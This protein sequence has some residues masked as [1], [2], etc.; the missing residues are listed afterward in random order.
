MK[1]FSHIYSTDFDGFVAEVA[2]DIWNKIIDMPTF[3]HL[4]PK[5]YASLFEA[6]AGSLA[7][8]HHEKALRAGRYRR[9]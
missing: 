8:Y 2:A 1:R 5:D 7:R 9:S 6:I 4:K 3:Y